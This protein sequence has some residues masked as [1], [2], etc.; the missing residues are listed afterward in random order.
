MG[1]ISNFNAH[2]FQD[3]VYAEA[4]RAIREHIVNNNPDDHSNEVSHAE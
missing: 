3:D 1:L 2:T 4:L